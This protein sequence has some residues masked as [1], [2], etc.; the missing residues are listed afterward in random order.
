MLASAIAPRVATLIGLRATVV[1]SVLIM[2]AAM[3]G[4]TQVEADW[5]AGLEIAVILVLGF[6]F[7]LGVP[8][9]TDSIKASVPVQDAGVGSAVNDVSRELGSALGV[10]ILGSIINSLYRANVADD[11]GGVV[12]EETVELAREGIGVLAAAS[13]SLPA[14]VAQTAV[15]A[16]GAAFIDAMNSGFWVSAGVMLVAALL[17]PRRARVQQV[18][19]EQVEQADQGDLVPAFAGAEEGP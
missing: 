19:R 17:L 13:T 18:E 9:L 15:P 10:A 1:I 7:G 12:P 3:V 8:S 4:F 11:L 2:T 6:G 14:D 16:A 5:S